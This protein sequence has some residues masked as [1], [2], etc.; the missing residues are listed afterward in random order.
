MSEV[1]Y[2]TTRL[3]RRRRRVNWFKLIGFFS[4]LLILAAVAGAAFVYY[5]LHTIH[6]TAIETTPIKKHERINILFLGVDAYQDPDGRVVPMKGFK[7]RRADTILLLSADPQQGELAII[8]IPRDTMVY[9]AEHNSNEKITD[10]HAYDAGGPSVVKR[11]LENDLL[12]IP[13]HYVIRT[14]FQGFVALVD[15]I[16][17]IDMEVEKRM[18]YSDPYQDLL[19]D[20]EPGFQHMDGNKALMYSRY[21][22]DGVGDIGRIQRQQKLI[23]IIADKVLNPKMIFRIPQIV[24][25]LTKYVDTNMTSG[26]ILSYAEML[27]SLDNLRIESATLPGNP[28]WVYESRYGGKVSY[29]V[30]DKVATQE[31]MDGLVRGI[32]REA[33]SAITV[34]VLNGSG[35][36]NAAQSFA[37]RLAA[38]GFQIV[39][40]G[41]APRHDYA[42]TVIIDRIG[43]HENVMRVSRTAFKLGTEPKEARDRQPEPAAMITVIV[44]ADYQPK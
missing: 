22:N 40:V 9:M 44:G 5:S 7:N 12:R 18:Y 32:D 42:A 27:R 34:Q 37:D 20:L 16:G 25:E 13:I 26:E 11:I 23:K 14:D 21:R 8:S 17:G 29:W 36:A 38:D 41:N 6:N 31:L 33:N 1:G 43:S 30:V 39:G 2:R 4:V 35:V 24:S 10:V 28:E 3:R 15:A 19:I